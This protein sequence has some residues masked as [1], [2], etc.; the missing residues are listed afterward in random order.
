MTPKNGPP[1]DGN[2]E[3]QKRTSNKE[4]VEPQT[5]ATSSVNH[6][7]QCCGA[8]YIMATSTS[9]TICDC[10]LWHELNR[11]QESVDFSHVE[12]PGAEQLDEALQATA[13]MARADELVAGI[14]GEGRKPSLRTVDGVGTDPDTFA[15]LSEALA[16]LM[17]SCDNGDGEVDTIEV[18]VDITEPGHL[19]FTFADE[20][21]INGNDST[22][23]FADT[24]VYNGVVS[25]IL[26]ASGTS[27]TINDLVLLPEYDTGG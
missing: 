23:V 11:I 21:V 7:E 12:G 18:T 2:G 20:V 26:N 4:H 13:G 22:I 24:A 1:P 10:R 25:N 3:R 27:V 5:D 17:A 9:H 15:T 14:C 6:C 16:D 19:G 8:G